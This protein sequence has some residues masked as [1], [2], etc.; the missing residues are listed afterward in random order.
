MSDTNHVEQDRKVL[1][2]FAVNNLDLGRLEA[3][4]D[5]FNIFEAVGLVW[6]EVRHST[7]L[8]FLLDPRAS[9]GLG[10]AF[11]KRLLRVQST[12]SGCWRNLCTLKSRT[13]NAK[14]KS[15]EVGQGS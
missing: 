6:Q 9:H 7:F 8:A 2:A 13:L 10:D 14:L 4:L 3:L 5:R 15:A 1:E 11:T 12:I